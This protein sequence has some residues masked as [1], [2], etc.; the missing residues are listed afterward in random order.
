MSSIKLNDFKVQLKIGP[1]GAMVGREGSEVQV[2][3]GIPGGGQSMIAW[4]VR[5]PGDLARRPLRLEEVPEPDPGPG[6][7]R[8]KV[9]ACG[10]CRTDLHIAEG[11]LMPPR[12]PVIPG[13]QVVGAV[14]RVGP[15]VAGIGLR[16]R[17]GAYWLH[18]SC[19]RCPACSRGEENLCPDARFLGFH[20]DGGFAE[21]VVIPA[22]YTVPIPDA[23]CDSQAA[24]LLCAGIIGYRALRLAELRPGETLALFGF[25]ASAH[26]VLQV[27]HHWGCRVVV[28]TRSRSRQEMARALGAVWSGPP[29]ESPLLADRAITFAPAGW[30]VLEALKAVRPGGTVA[31]NAV[32]MSDVPSFPYRVI[33]G[34]R[35]LRTVANVTRKDAAEFMQVAAEVPVTA[36]VVQYPFHQADQAL[37]DL[38]EGK[39][40]G[41]AVL[42]LGR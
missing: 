8:L 41:A 36:R 3:K 30:V 10:V 38:K 24:P 27:A 40:D 5:D 34:E 42:L 33:Y 39:V 1:F 19:G 29:G 35:T 26:L 23:F 22:E 14:D 21:Y 12:L 18:S 2:G 32:Y 11:E 4:V 20:A 16:E 9:R 17:R 31:V 15:G 25:G 6:E 28:Y 7:V 37:L 13:H